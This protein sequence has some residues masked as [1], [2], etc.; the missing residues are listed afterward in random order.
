MSTT[1]LTTL[2]ILVTGMVFTMV[3]LIRGPSSADRVAA[4]DVLSNL[5]L[6]FIIAYAVGT[7]EE[8]LLDP[9][10]G[11]AVVTFLATIAFTRYLAAR[12]ANG[13]GGSR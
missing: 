3:R 12:S 4:I 5:A 10:L 7:D 2:A 13:E 11:L 6:G 9:A 1:V 8:M